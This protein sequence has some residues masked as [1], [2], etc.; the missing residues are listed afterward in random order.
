[1][2]KVL[3]LGLLSLWVMVSCS[4]QEPILL[5]FSTWLS[6]KNSVLGI[7]GRDAV[8]LAVD[9]VNAE[10]GIQGRKVELIIMD[11]QGQAEKAVEA[12]RLLIEQ[13]CVAI[14]GHMTSS[15][16]LAALDQINAEKI[17]MLSPTA[18]SDQ[19]AGMEDYFFRIAPMSSQEINQLAQYALEDLAVKNLVCIY[20]ESNASFSEKWVEG[21]GMELRE[22]DL[23]W[24]GLVAFDSQEDPSFHTLA[25]E[26]SR[27]DAQ[28]VLIVANSFDT[29]LICQNLRQ[30]NSEIRLLSTGWANS[31]DLLSNGGSAVDGL[32][33][34]QARDLNS[35]SEKYLNFKQAFID[36]YGKDPDMASI[37]SYEAAMLILEKLKETTDRQEFFKLIKDTHNWKGLQREI[38][39]DAYGDNWQKRYY[40]MEIQAGEMHTI[41][42]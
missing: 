16:S 40:I 5:G 41:R 23:Q 13:G 15:M 22:Q 42:D 25:E 30:I 38:N 1:M 20:D 9:Q 35:Q 17:L 10:G 26:I 31:Q 19:L 27:Y 34:A 37:Y 32:L 21:F 14:I 4:E 24:K 12:D 33:F 11:D 3:I 18:S 29:A 2:K 6:G 39:W 8:Q 28:A 36:S 7:A